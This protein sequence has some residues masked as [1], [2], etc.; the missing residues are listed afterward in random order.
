MN[1]GVHPTVHEL[2]HPVAEASL[3]GFEGDLYGKFLRLELLF[4]VRPEQHFSSLTELTARSRATSDGAL[5]SD[6][7]IIP[8]NPGTERF[9]FRLLRV[10]ACRILQIAGRI[11]V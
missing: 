1:L 5:S 11:K 4:Q 7:R 6:R 8:R 10:P 2:P 3:L 9:R